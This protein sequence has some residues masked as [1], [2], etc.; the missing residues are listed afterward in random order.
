MYKITF[1]FY[2]NNYALLIYSEVNLLKSMYKK[3]LKTNMKH[4]F[5][6]FPFLYVWVEKLNL[7]FF[8]FIPQYD[9]GLHY[10]PWISEDF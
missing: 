2:N 6:G 4:L 8:V 5:A 1:V 9:Q 10:F 3:H 7:I